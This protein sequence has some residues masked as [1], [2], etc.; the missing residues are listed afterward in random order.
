MFVPGGDPSVAALLRQQEVEEFLLE[1]Y[2]HCKTIAASGAGVGLL[3]TALAGKFSE[4]DEA[5]KSVVSNE[6]VVI[7][8]DGSPKDLASAFIEAITLHR[9][10]G[11]EVDHEKEKHIA[12]RAKT[13]I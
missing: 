7:S 3:A 9:H 8:R 13:T 5:G 10:W 12:A 2:K 6:G 4:P 1:S 11:R